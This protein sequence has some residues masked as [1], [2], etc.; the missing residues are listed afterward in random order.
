[1]LLSLLASS[2][3]L[4]VAVNAQ[5][6][7]PNVLMVVADDLGRNDLAHFNEGKSST[8]VL[9]ELIT[10]GIFL[11]SYY[12][13][14]VCSPTRTSIMSGRYA[15][16]TGF[17]D[18]V[19]DAGHTL[20]SNY[21]MLPKLLINSGYS[22]HA[23]GKWNI[24]G[25]VAS[26]TPTYNG[27]E[28]FLGY[29]SACT[30]DYFYHNA[31]GCTVPSDSV[32]PK[33]L[34]NNTGQT[35][36]GANAQFTGLY[37]THVYTQRAVEIVNSHAAAPKNAD[38][39]MDPL[40]IYLAYQNV[41]LACGNAK[42]KE[43]HLGGIQAPCATIDRFSHVQNDTFKAQSANMLEL[44]W[45]VGNVTAAFKE[46]NM[47][48]NTAFILVSDNGGPLDHT[49]N[50]PLKGGKHTF[51]EG[52]VRV[53]AF[54]SGP[55]IPMSRRGSIY[56]GMLHSSDWYLTIVQG[57]ANA[58]VPDYTGPT[59][60][61]GFNAW[62]AIMANATSPRNE[63]IHQVK[64][65]YFND[66]TT[67]YALRVGDYKLIVGDPGDDRCL[68]WPT[69]GNQAVKF[70]ESGGNVEGAT[71]NCRAPTTSHSG[72]GHNNCVKTPCL[73]NVVT[74][75]VEENDLGSNPKY[76][77]VLQSLQQRLEQAG[78]EGPPL[79]LAYPYTQEQETTMGNKICAD[80]KLTGYWEPFDVA[81]TISN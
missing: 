68:A 77:T 57:L 67:G 55:L 74:D 23:I 43:F 66:S 33:D 30:S 16:R 48:N 17:Y 60:I 78:T 29:Y 14:K 24:G 62:D 70:G 51:W 47:W 9:N 80:A 42:K 18:M 37:S 35:I 8:P 21:S 4:V 6:T 49:T 73:F 75:P 40:F 13:F 53:V 52:G 72:D 44:D 32:Y 19:N 71:G 26:S 39:T 58:D 45:G 41:H 3:A 22:S 15:W 38:G 36:K 50:F 59:P 56:T 31:S 81:P 28:T 7:K 54:V 63:V 10:E 12:T 76:Q 11:E 61:D 34:S 46:Q 69:Q 65:Q 20:N 64:N 27:F 1:M 25:I 79:S 5:S 2:A